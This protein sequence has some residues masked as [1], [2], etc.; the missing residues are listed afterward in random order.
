M[1][2]PIAGIVCCAT[3]VILSPLSGTGATCFA[4]AST[5]PA[6]ATSGTGAPGN[7]PADADSAVPA[8]TPAADSTVNTLPAPPVTTAPAATPTPTAPPA[9]IVKP[10]SFDSGFPAIPDDGGAPTQVTLRVHTDVSASIVHRERTEYYSPA[11][12]RW[13]A[14]VVLSAE[15]VQNEGADHFTADIQ[16]TGV[17]TLR[18]DYKMEP[19]LRPG[20]LAYHLTFS[21]DA[22][23]QLL[24]TSDKSGGLSFDFPTDPV[25]AGSVWTGTAW[26]RGAQTPVLFHLDRIVRHHGHDFAQITASIPATP[27]FRARYWFDTTAGTFAGHEYLD[28]KTLHDGSTLFVRSYPVVKTASLRAKG[29]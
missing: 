25:G 9:T 19:K 18:D 13:T 3:F 10:R 21:M 14:F 11:M 15:H 29:K 24:S 12:N 1:K 26:R 17:V 16:N 6:P 28:Q 8:V 20:F 23:G 4:Q 5:S 22:S 7:P 27:T 2:P